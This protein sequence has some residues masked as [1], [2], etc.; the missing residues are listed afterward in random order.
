MESEKGI[1]WLT[2]L[3]SCSLGIYLI[4]K[5]AMSYELYFLQIKVDNVYWRFLGPFLTYFLCLS[6]VLVI[7]RIPYLRGGFP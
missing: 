7:K 2:I 3:S 4:H 6:I 1:K 5:L